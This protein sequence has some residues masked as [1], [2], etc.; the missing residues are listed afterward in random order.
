MQAS[1]TTPYDPLEL[2]TA[3]EV[4]AL[5]K[6]RKDYVYDAAQAGQL[7]SIKFGHQTVRFRRCDV[8]AYVHSLTRAAK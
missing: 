3:D 8:E 7:A 1:T 2:L 6:I 5:L 4:A